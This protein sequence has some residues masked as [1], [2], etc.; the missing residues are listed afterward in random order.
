MNMNKGVL[1]ISLALAGIFTYIVAINV[2][3]MVFS[4]PGISFGGEDQTSM[5]TGEVRISLS[6]SVSTSV[7]RNRWYG[8]I[9]EDGADSD[10]SRTLYTLGLIP[11][12]LESGGVS[13]LFF[14]AILIIAVLGGM[15]GVA[16][17]MRKRAYERGYF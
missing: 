17:V 13:L 1:W 15:Y 7:K 6:D 14:H 11:L 5:D 12:P 4:I 10:R 3:A 8:T 2:L 16:Q 9:L